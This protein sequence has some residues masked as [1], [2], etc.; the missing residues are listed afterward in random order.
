[1]GS[2]VDDMLVGSSLQEPGTSPK[3]QTITSQD[4]FMRAKGQSTPTYFSSILFPNFVQNMPSLSSQS[5][6]QSSSASSATNSRRVNKKKN[7]LN[8]SSPNDSRFFFK[9]SPKQE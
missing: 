5:N 9:I 7:N 2:Y 4:A 6:L 8:S 3:N 1:M